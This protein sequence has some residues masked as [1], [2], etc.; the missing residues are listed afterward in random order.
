L[1]VDALGRAAIRI[2]TL[3]TWIWTQGH[4]IM[5]RRYGLRLTSRGGVACFTAERGLFGDALTYG[6]KAIGF[7]TAVPATQVLLDQ[8]RRVYDGHGAPCRIHVVEGLTSPEAIRLLRR[9]GFRREEFAFEWH[10]RVAGRV[11]LIPESEDLRV[12]RVARDEATLFSTTARDAFGDT[13][14]VREY[15]HRTLVALLR[16]HPRWVSGFLA[17]LDGSPAGTGGLLLS[18][19]AAG[20]FSGAVLSRHRGRGIQSALIAARIA[21]GMRRGVR[22]FFSQTHENPVSAGNLAE[23]GFRQR[24]RIVHWSAE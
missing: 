6:H 3:S 7:G 16:D 13:G 9:N 2:E 4:P 21:Y 23:L 8:V 5:R 22:V 18:A 15:F 24:W 12:H 11:P 20:L 17:T 19:G 1:T 10:A 14:R